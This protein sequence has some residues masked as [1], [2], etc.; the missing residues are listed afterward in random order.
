MYIDKRAFKKSPEEL[1]MYLYFKKRGFRLENKKG[2][3]SYC[4][5]KKHASADYD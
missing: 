4:R 5:K 2:R 1:Q 3:G